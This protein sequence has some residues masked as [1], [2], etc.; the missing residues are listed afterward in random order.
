VLVGKVLGGSSAVNM[1]MT[2]RGTEE[3]Y[4]RWG[5]FFSNSSDWSWKGMLPY[6]KKALNFHPPNADVAK[7]VNMTWDTSY[8]GNTSGVSTSWPSYQ[9]P[10]VKVIMDAWRQTP[11][12]EMP[13]DSG[14]G[15]PGVFWY[16]QFMDPKTVTRSYARTGHYSNVE[17]P[18][19]HV[20]TGSKVNK[21][22]F[23]GTTATGITFV[24]VAGLSR[25]GTSS[26]A[27]TTVLARKEVIL[28]ASGIHSP[29]ILQLSGI[30]P[31]KL[32][33]AA[34]ITTIVDLPGVGQNFQDHPMIS[35]QFSC[36]SP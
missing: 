26:S 3:D 7:S 14:S 19:Y 2:L 23:D 12:I 27:P 13:P 30:G 32:L 34:N 17:R 18:N 29:Q 5:K 21:I 22:L 20:I 15:K 25:A 28:A 33:A 16:P 1:M 11:G 31:Q 10:T 6:F 36:K 8:W 4:D 35:A 9:Y 24:P